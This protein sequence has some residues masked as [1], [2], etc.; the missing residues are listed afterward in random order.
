MGI[1]SGIK[2]KV[3]GIYSAHSVRTRRENL[4]DL[5]EGSSHQIKKLS[6]SRTE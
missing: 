2:W 4:Q 1:E 5:L 3:G 6:G